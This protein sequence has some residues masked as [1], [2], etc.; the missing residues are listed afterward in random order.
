MVSTSDILLRIRGQDQTGNAFKSVEEKANGMKSTLSNAVGMAMGMVG[1]D[2]VNSFVEAGR[3]AV[4]ASGQLDYFT[5]RLGMSEQQTSEYRSQ[6]DSMQRE[7]K[8]VNMT[9]VGAT[10]T[11]LAARY[12]LPINKVGDLTKMTAV[13]SSEFLRN[14]RTQEDSVLAVADAMDGQFKRLQEIGITQE[15]LKANGWNGNL[16]DQASLID[17]INKN[18]EASGYDKIAKDIT[19]LDDAYQALTVSGGNLIGSVLIPLT[20]LIVGISDAISNAIYFIQDNGWAQ[21][22]LLIG[23]LAVG[24]GLFAGALS[25]A[26]AA[27]GGLMALMPG[28]ITSLYGAASG[29]MAISIAGAPLWAI[30]AVIAAIALAVYEVGIY[31]GW[32]KDIGTM[33]E[34]ISDGVRRLWE[35]FINNPKVQAAIKAVQNALNELWTFIQPVISWIQE[36]FNNLFGEAG[37]NPDAVRM[38]WEAFE[39]LGNVASTVFGYLQQGF[40][41]VSYVVTPLW[42]GLMT[43]VGIFGQLQSGAI[44]WQDAL[45]GILSTISTSFGNFQLRL[46]QIA[47]RIGSA[48]LG[49]IVGY[50]SQIPGRIWSFLS[51]AGM[52]I[53]MFGN[54]AA[55]RARAAGMRILMGFVNYLMQLPGRVGSYL[56]QVPGRITSAAGAAVGAAASL[57]SQVVQAVTNGVVGVAEHVYNEFMAIPDRINGAVSAAASA[58]A[59]FGSGIKDAVLNALHIASP[60]II[61]RK[62]AIEF[63]DIPGRI[64]ES[65][66]Y[67]YSAARDYAG[68]IL[69]GFNAPQMT[70]SSMGVMRQNSSYVPTNAVTGATTI[71][72]IGAGA[73]PIDARNMTASEAVGVVTAAFED[74]FDNPTGGVTW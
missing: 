18:M 58:A 12:Q 55:A 64:G 46:A 51:Q 23:G 35:A 72:Y 62:I 41:A 63:A 69:K 43:I 65:F 44:S 22:A 4:N 48:I 36:G 70:L 68:N 34:A 60:G 45:L 30:L 20:P 74:I 40:Q 15:T 11:D 37:S 71:V 39:Q 25:V 13:M 2:L 49:A 50:L 17:A 38:I 66:G 33:L 14:G 28:F 32:W 3:E 9:S 10:A 8:K 73:I 61:Q 1:Y 67:V 54:T 47:L 21:G 26:A 52:R 19:N 59:N 31:F 53:L 56:M 42:N 6:L 5:G 27:E 29:F 16:Q 7:F 57:A 24:F